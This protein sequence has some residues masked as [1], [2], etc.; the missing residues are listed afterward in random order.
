M[1]SP[2]RF[3]RSPIQKLLACVPCLREPNCFHLS[4]E[5]SELLFSCQMLLTIQ[6]RASLPL[7]S[8]RNT[9]G[10]P[11]SYAIYFRGLSMRKCPTAHLLET[12]IPYVIVFRRA[13][14]PV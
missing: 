8:P 6:P 1:H 10:L 2:G 13:S 9:L 11:G 4:Q 5:P 12:N 14:T 3:S 7:L